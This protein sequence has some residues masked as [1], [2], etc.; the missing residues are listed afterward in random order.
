MGTITNVATKETVAS[1]TFDDGPHPEFTPRLLDVLKKHDAHATFF[2]IGK[3]AQQ[4][5]E[6]LRRVEQEG[7]AICNH[8]WDHP[9]FPLITG[10]ERRA[11]IRACAEAIA[12]YGQRIFRPPYGDQSIASR[13]DA[14]RLGYKVVTWNILAKDWLD[15]DS[16]WIVNMV[17]K[18][19][20][21][22][23]VILFHDALHDV[24]EHR[25][26]AR[27]PM[28]DAVEMLLERVGDGFRFVTIPDLLHSGRPYLDNWFKKPDTDLLNKL[29]A[30]HGTARRYVLKQSTNRPNIFL[31]K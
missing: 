25:Y 4:Y 23:S 7:H 21:P 6:L 2:V 22:G 31:N 19:I 20:R 24:I 10:R 9:S 8:S 17:L 14:L 5:P 30:Q 15:H 18:K 12:P 3:I 28:L 1:L 13:F 29:I 16:N 11:Q 26:A 27:E